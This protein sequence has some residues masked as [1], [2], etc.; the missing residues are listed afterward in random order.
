MDK[1]L[2]GEKRCKQRYG[3]P[4]GHTSGRGLLSNIVKYA[5]GIGSGLH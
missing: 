2:S 3:R 1:E 4:N 5:G